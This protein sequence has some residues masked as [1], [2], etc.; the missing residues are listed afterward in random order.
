MPD[1]GAQVWVSMLH[2]E[3]VER[4]DGLAPR[5]W[6]CQLKLGES[7]RMHEVD[8][9]ELEAAGYLADGRDVIDA[10]NEW[11]ADRTSHQTDNHQDQAD[12]GQH[13]TEYVGDG[14][15]RVGE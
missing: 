12:H 1:C 3:F 6:D 8:R 5:C 9:V 14:G 4:A 10:M 11:L 13:N 15:Q 2:L 7:V